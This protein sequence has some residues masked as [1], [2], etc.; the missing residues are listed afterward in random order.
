MVWKVRKTMLALRTSPRRWQDH[1]SGK[2]KEHGFRQDERDAGLF[3]NEELDVYIGVHVDDMLVVG[4]SE[5]TTTLLQE[6][7]KDMAMRRSM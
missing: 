1:L 6:L 7:A 2:L 3:V 4:P 5:S